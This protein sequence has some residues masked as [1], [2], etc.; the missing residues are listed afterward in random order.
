M[1]KTPHYWKEEDV[2]ITLV[3]LLSVVF[4]CLCTWLKNPLAEHR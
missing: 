1:P 4:S 3:K 2:R